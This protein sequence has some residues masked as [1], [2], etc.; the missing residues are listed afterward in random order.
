MEGLTSASGTYQPEGKCERRATGRLARQS[1][2]TIDLLGTS[3]L[4]WQWPFR[5]GHLG[6]REE[7]GQRLRQ[8]KEVA[9]VI[10]KQWL[11]A[12]TLLDRSWNA[13]GS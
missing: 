11:K 4:T 5:K 12:V 10:K 9:V 6:P 8:L 3:S 13:H 1:K 2:I 7:G